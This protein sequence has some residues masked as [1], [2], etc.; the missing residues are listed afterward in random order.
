MAFPQ[1]FFGGNTRW[2]LLCLFFSAPKNPQ[3]LHDF[4]PKSPILTGTCI[5]SDFFPVDLFR[6]IVPP[7]PSLVN[8]MTSSSANKS[9]SPP[10]SISVTHVLAL[11]TSVLAL[12]CWHLRQCIFDLLPLNIYSWGHHPLKCF[13]KALAT[14]L[15]TVA[16]L[17]GDEANAFFWIKEMHL[18]TLRPTQDSKQ[19]RT[20]EC[21]FSASQIV[22][23]NSLVL[24]N[25][26]WTTNGAAAA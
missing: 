24:L 21:I 2:I 14:A 25:S 12:A 20:A 16:A 9:M 26:S 22:F 3:S 7:A 6:H 8:L 5:D 18:A 19:N 10:L 11:V 23:C 17:M 1:L 4:A 13:F 15:E